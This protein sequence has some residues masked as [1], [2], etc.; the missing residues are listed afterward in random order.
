[1]T[2]IRG[3]ALEILCWCGCQPYNMLGCTLS[4]HG[5]RQRLALLMVSMPQT[6]HWLILPGLLLTGYQPGSAFSFDSL[7]SQ[8]MRGATCAIG[9]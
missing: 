1:M 5:G 8:A 3:N 9:V 4:V 2:K 7:G 6:L